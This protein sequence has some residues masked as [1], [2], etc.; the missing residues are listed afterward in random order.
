MFEKFIRYAI[1]Q[2]SPKFVPIETIIDWKASKEC[3][4][5]RIR[6]REIVSKCLYTNS[7]T[8]NLFQWISSA[9]MEKEDDLHNLKS[10]N[11]LKRNTLHKAAI[12]RQWNNREGVNFLLKLKSYNSA[13]RIDSR[14]DTI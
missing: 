4:N 3:R 8:S 11:I 5:S 14:A 2:E 10:L 13:K 6:F 7:Q 9:R 12:S 1:Y